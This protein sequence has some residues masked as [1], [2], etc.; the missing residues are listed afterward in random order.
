MSSPRSIRLEISTL[1]RL[2]SYATRHSGVTSASAA[3]RFVE[4]GLRMDSHPGIVFRDGAAGRRAVIAGGPD[5]WEVIRVI[6]ETRKAEALLTPIEV[7]ELVSANGGV[8]AKH[9]RLAMDYYG[10][11]PGEI[12]VQIA[13][14]AS[15]EEALRTTFARSNALLGT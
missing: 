6:M 4:E 8:S 5:V 13:E 2:S 1:E 11:F 14:A 9:V 3:A 7:L 12:D 15:A 10:E